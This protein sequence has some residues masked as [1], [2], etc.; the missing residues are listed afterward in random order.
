MALRGV[1]RLGE[2]CIRVLDMAAARRHYGDHLGLHEVSDY[3]PPQQERTR[4]RSEKWVGSLSRLALYFGWLFIS[5]GCLS[6]LAL[7]LGRLNG[8]QCRSLATA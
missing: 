7:Y 3:T 4:I 1:L 5:V 6:R 8:M 2:V